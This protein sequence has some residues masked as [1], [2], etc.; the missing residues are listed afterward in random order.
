MLLGDVEYSRSM[1][2]TFAEGLQCDRAWGQRGMHGPFSTQGIARLPGEKGQV[3][4]MEVISAP[5]QV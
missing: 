5:A 3:A 4:V 2:Y 1:K